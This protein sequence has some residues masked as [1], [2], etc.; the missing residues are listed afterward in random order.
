M[1]MYLD[2]RDS[3]EDLGEVKVRRKYNQVKLYEKR[4][5]FQ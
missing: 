3:G 4:I 1:G 5:Y 2:E